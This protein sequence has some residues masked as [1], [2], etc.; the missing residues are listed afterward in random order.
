MFKGNIGT[1]LKKQVYNLCVFPAMTYGAERWAT[2]TQTKNNLAVEQ[3]KLERSR[4]NII[5]RDRN[6]NIWVR[7][8]TKVIDVI[9]RVKRWMWTWPAHVSR[10]RDNRWTIPIIIWKLYERNILWRDELE[11]TGRSPSGRG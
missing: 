6:T 1:W 10:I 3:T 4:L 8:K 7:E 9:E 11:T 2:T 5:Y